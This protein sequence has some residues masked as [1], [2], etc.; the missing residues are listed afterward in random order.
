[1]RYLLTNQDHSLLKVKDMGRFALSQTNKIK[2]LEAQN[3]RCAYCNVGLDEVEIEYD[4][5][6][7]RA[8]RRD[9]RPQNIVAACRA[10]NQSKKDRI[11]ATEADLRAFCMEMIKNHGSRGSG[12]PEGVTARFLA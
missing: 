9:D 6:I 11:L 3:C 4:H 2:I 12:T 5:F 1:M 7:P 8:W 10:C